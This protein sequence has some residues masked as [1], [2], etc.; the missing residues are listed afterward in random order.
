MSAMRKNLV[1]KFLIPEVSSVVNPTI[2]VIDGYPIYPLS[3]NEIENLQKLYGKNTVTESKPVQW[4]TIVFHATVHPF[5]ILLLALAI[6]SAATG[7]IDTTII[8]IV[9]VVLSVVL[10]SV[11]EFRSEVAAQGLKNLVN[12]D[13]LVVRQ[14]SSP[15]T[16]DPLPEDILRMERGDIGEY[17]VPFEDI[18]PGDWIKLRAG[19]LIPADLQLIVS[20]DLFISQASLTGEAMPVEKSASGMVMEPSSSNIP[21]TGSVPVS[22]QEEYGLNRPD[23]CFMGTSVVSGTATGVVKTVGTST[24]FGAMAK[25]LSAQRPINAFQKGIRRISYLF[26]GIMLL[27]VPLVFIISGITNHD[28]LQAALFAASVALVELWFSQRKNVS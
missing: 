5:N 6:F 8:M 18:V 3:W 19:D 13:C 26:I 15:D 1:E 9:M 12:N 20:K 25:Q 16:R 14:Y 22:M 17:D 7:E 28:W 24:V 21:T 23:M 11:Q 4:Y 27:M 10:R 2:G